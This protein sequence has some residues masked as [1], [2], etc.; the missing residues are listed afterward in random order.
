MTALTCTQHP[1]YLSDLQ[2][3]I[4]H[5]RV[6]HLSSITRP[7]RPGTVDTHGHMWYCWACESRSLKDHRSFD[8]NEAMWEHLRSRH[9]DIAACI[10]PYED[11]DEI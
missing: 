5:I 10:V 4:E 11:F 2:E 3:A 9:C 6:Y 1:Q 7:G 8:A